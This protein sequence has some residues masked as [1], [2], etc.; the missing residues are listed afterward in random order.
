LVNQAVK[1]VRDMNKDKDEGP[2]Y[3]KY[4]KALER[5]QRKVVEAVSAEYLGKLVVALE[6]LLEEQAVDNDA[7][8]PGM[9]GLWAL[10][11]MRGVAQQLR[12]LKKPSE[13]GAPLLLARRYGKGNTVAFLSSAGTASK[14]NEWGA[15]GPAQDTYAPFIMDLQRYLI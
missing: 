1:I 9:P 2:N 12:P 8:R 15:D 10:P 4:E 5:H 7:D 6:N 13:C 11:R 3:T 14:W